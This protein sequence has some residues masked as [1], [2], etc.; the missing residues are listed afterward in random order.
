MTEKKDILFVMNNLNVG[1]AEKALVSLLQVFDY[2]KYNVDL[3]L[4][5]KEGLFLKQVPKEVNLLEEPKNFKYFDMPFSQ[6]VKENIFED[7]NVIFRRI[8]FKLQ[9]KK[10]KNSAESEQFGWK[11]LAKTLS[12]PPKKY[13]AAIGFL[14]KSPNYY[15]VEKV[16]ANIKIGFIHN[17]YISLGMNSKYD[18]DYFRKLDYI[19]TVSEECVD[20]L[21]KSFPQLLDKIKLIRNISP[22]K[23]LFEQ[24]EESQLQIQNK[25]KYILSIGRLTEQKAFDKAIDAFALLAEKYPDLEWLVL[26]EGNL[27]TELEHQIEEKKLQ[28]R[29]H[30]LGSVENPYPFIKNCLI[31][32]QTSIFEGKSIA[33]DEAKIFAKPIVVTNYPS[34]KDQ[35]VDGETGLIAEM[36]P[37]DIANKIESLILDEQLGNILSENLR[38]EEHCDESEIEKLYKLIES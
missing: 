13:Q 21:N 33:I 5:K 31:F 35:I 26:G 38:K 25:K 10:S 8:K 24:A 28:N 2:D 14:E 12:P 22:K 17:D 27:R 37:H 1:G 18:D 9:S 11:P 15:V 19:A 3:L 16:Q 29:F 30:L 20:S 4:F 36:D 7:W 23:R 34:A 32:V 6:V